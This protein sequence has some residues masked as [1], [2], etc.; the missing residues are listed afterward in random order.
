MQRYLQRPVSSLIRWKLNSSNFCETFFFLILTVEMFV[1]MWQILW[2]KQMIT[3]AIITPAGLGL[4]QELVPQSQ[5]LPVFPLSDWDPLLLAYDRM[6]YLPVST[7]HCTARD[8]HG[9]TCWWRS[10]TEDFEHMS[11]SFSTDVQWVKCSFCCPGR[12]D[13]VCSILLLSP[14]YEVT[15]Y[16]S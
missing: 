8:S 12:V 1:K 4:A 14:N 7:P 9:W 2:L 3:Y 13:E 15:D 10:T 11:H 16:Y 6:L 5:L